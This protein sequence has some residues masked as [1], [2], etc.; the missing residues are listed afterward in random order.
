M[1][2][3]LA[4]VSHI[5]FISSCIALFFAPFLLVFYVKN[6]Y[7][8]HK[9]VTFAEFMEAF[10]HAPE[11]KLLIIAWVFAESLFWF[12]APE[13]LL[14]FMLFLPKKRGTKII[15][16]DFIGI[17]A[18][19]VVG[20][21][22]PLSISFINHTPYVYP[23][24]LT[25]VSEWYQSYGIFG[26]LFQPFSGI[27][28]KV[29]IAEAVTIGLPFVSFIVVAVA[30]RMTRY[31][32]FFFT[33]QFIRRFTHTFIGRHFFVYTIIVLVVFSISLLKVALIYQ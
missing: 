8:I 16:Y 14:V 22:L 12:V 30:I 18:G 1:L 15:L 32:V 29:F 31:A 26:L 9:T 33:F 2:S 4:I 7:K 23:G 21:L 6:R 3:F 24:M 20:L 27:P 11:A 19:T 25:S 5:L 10:F 17:L 28:Y 13:F